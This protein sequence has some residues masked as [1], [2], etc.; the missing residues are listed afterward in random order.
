MTKSE[1]DKWFP[2][3]SKAEPEQEEP[4]EHG[5]IEGV[6]RPRPRRYARRWYSRINK[7]HKGGNDGNEAK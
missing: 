7:I 2:R 3:P 5:V 4:T 6:K 1:L